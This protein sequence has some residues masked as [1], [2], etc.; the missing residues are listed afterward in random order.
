MNYTNMIE[1]KKL[2]KTYIIAI[3]CS[4]LIGTFT[5]SMG[6]YE[7]I[8][9]KRKQGKKDSK[10]DE[11][12]KKLQ[13]AEKHGREGARESWKDTWRDHDGD[14]VGDNLGM[15]GV[16]IQRQY[17]EGYGRLGR[18][19][20]IGDT[21]TEN[22][23]QAQII[24]LQQTVIHILQDALYHERPLTRSDQAK[25]IAASN[26]AREGSLNALRQQQLRLNMENAPRDLSRSLA[27]RS[28]ASSVI[29]S[30]PLF[31]R[32]SLDLQY[33]PNKPLATSFAPGESRHCP[34][35]GLRLAVASD[36]FWQ[37]D[38]RT[39]MIIEVG[40]YEKEVMETREFHLGQRFVIKCHTADG[41]Y[42]CVLCSRHRD[43]DAICRS[44][45]AL[46]N[47][48]G[49]YHEVEELEKE[50]DL[51]EHPPMRKLLAIAPPP[52]PT[53]PLVQ[54][55]VREVRELEP[56]GRFR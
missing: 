41:E 47:H 4:T 26:S 27:P 39:P 24:A 5:S 44:A 11:D 15:A 19:F 12:I 25:I 49:N 51:R 28:R 17:E 34:A 48:V 21:Q 7:R 16:M 14:D 1:D 42:A 13:N 6:L 31:C 37:I 36:D 29:E 55:E 18:R 54:R 8:A 22:Q 56:V 3:L 33:I 43:V 52:A 35:C 53:P 50:V 45:E 9:D 30:D 10:Q 46:V 38:K 32:Y 2:K 20:A 40:G 23:L